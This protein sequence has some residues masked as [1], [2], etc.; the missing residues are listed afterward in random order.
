[1]VVGRPRVLHQKARVSNWVLGSVQPLNK[2]F[3]N[4]P[5]L[6]CAILYFCCTNFLWVGYEIFR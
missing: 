4:V 5:V 2:T 3:F 6:K 1:M